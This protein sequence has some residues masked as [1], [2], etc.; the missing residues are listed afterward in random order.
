VET[1]DIT[2]EHVNPVEGG[3]DDADQR[4]RHM[5]DMWQELHAPWRM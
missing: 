3:E 5:P 2:A 1:I 4:R